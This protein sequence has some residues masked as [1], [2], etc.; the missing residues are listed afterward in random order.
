[1]TRKYKFVLPDEKALVLEYS[2][3]MNPGNLATTC[4]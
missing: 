1:M 2:Y 3:K 4:R